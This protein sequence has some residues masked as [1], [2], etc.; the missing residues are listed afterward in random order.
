M[1]C[2]ARREVLKGMPSAEFLMYVLQRLSKSDSAPADVDV[3]SSCIGLGCIGIPERSFRRACWGVWHWGVCLPGNNIIQKVLNGFNETFRECWYGTGNKW[4][5]FG[6]VTGSGGSLFFKRSKTRGS[7][8]LCNRLY[9]LVLLLPLYTFPYYTK[10]KY[11]ILDYRCKL[12][13]VYK[14]DYEVYITAPHLHFF[15]RLF[16]EAPTKGFKT[17]FAVFPVLLW[18]ILS[19]QCLTL[20]SYL[21]VDIMKSLIR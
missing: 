9:N 12:L 5:H 2:L 10:L 19:L 6:D 17:P 1:Y 13:L 4:V 18:V 14:G 3:A 21:H 8:M 7:T 16:S 20:L 11:A 15:I